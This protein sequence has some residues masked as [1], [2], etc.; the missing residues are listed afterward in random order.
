MLKLLHCGDFHLD[1]PFSSLDPA[2]AEERRRGLLAVFCRTMRLA[3]DEKCDAVLIAGDLFDRSY[4]SPDT[5]SAMCEAMGG[6]GCPVLISPGNHDPYT[7]GSVW[8]ARKAVFPENVHVFRTEEPEAVDIPDSALTV[9]G[10]AFT[11]DR[12]DGS[13]LAGLGSL[14][15]PGRTSVLCAHA[16][17]VSPLSKY[18]P[19]A[20]RELAD[21]GLAYAALGHIHNTP[22]P[23]VFG[24]TTAAYCGFPE[25]RGFDEQGFGSVLIVT[26]DDGRVTDMRRVR[27]GM[28][29]YLTVRADASGARNDSEAA[30]AV[31]RAAEVE[32]PAATSLRVTLCGDV[33][34]GYIPDTAA[35]LSAAGGCG[36]YSLSVYDDT[37]PLAGCAALADDMTVRGELYRTLL[38][39]MRN[40]SD[41]E[42]RTAADALRL[43]LRALDGRSFL[44]GGGLN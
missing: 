32:E 39:M 25:G 18:A 7:E 34:A 1:S 29:R 22:D 38:P 17:I 43:G 16:D 11:S 12:Y 20:P 15:R 33:D 10:Y 13:P 30:E 41:E 9:W 44:D 40:G 28:H 35:I 27:V 2:H 4:I 31:R 24:F 3:A 37:M 26:L 19:I 36:L 8:A 5:V 23:A 6:T 14:A 42:R 21:S